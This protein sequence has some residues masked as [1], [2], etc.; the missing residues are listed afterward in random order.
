MVACAPYWGLTKRAS[1]KPAVVPRTVT[2]QISHL[3]R[4]TALNTRRQSTPPSDPAPPHSVVGGG[5]DGGTITGA[6]EP[7]GSGR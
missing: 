3:N 4:S 6:V 2:P 7:G 1:P 5:E